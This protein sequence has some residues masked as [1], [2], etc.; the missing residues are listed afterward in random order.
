MIV[1]GR[2]RSAA[3][4]GEN[5]VVDQESAALRAGGHQVELFQRHSDDIAGWPLR[6]KAALPATSLWNGQVRKELARRLEQMRPDVVHVHNTFPLL[7]PSVLYACRDAGVPVVATLH[8]YKLLCASGD[9]FRDGLPCH[10]CAPGHGLPG[11]RHGCYRGSRAATVPVVAA[12][13]WNRSAWQ[14]L[15]SAYIFISASQRELMRDLALPQQR[16]FVKHNLVPPALPPQEERRRA[17]VYLGRLDAAKGAR[18]LMQSWDAFR[19]RNPESALRL[20]VAGGGPLEDVVRDWADRHTSVDVVGLLTKGQ[21]V[22]L[23][24]GALAAV[25]PSQWEETFGLVAVEAMTSGVAPIAPA[26]G[27]FPELVTEGVDGV[28]FEP[29]NPLALAEALEE[30]DRDPQRYLEYGRQGRVTWEK[31]FHPAVNL[32]ELLAVYRFAVGNP[33][34]GH[35]VTP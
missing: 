1:H 13:A 32:D 9:F 19:D 30:V 4:S 18:L 5:R 31:R 3:P 17:V 20:V 11:V 16:V 2:Y 7:S 12:A 15:V 26:R 33:A 25:V 22:Q 28:L 14:R 35:D 6:K 23:L 21:A 8:N 10:D 34:S 27:S 24:R 29:G